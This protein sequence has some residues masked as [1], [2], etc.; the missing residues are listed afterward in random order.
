MTTDD[1]DG[2]RG[3]EPQGTDVGRREELRVG[4]RVKLELRTQGDVTAL[5]L[6]GRA[7][8]EYLERLAAIQSLG[9]LLWWHLG[10]GS[11][12]HRG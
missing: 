3:V 4:M 5:D 11:V 10:Q 7:D 12:R 6:L 2:S 1:G 9:Q 8:I